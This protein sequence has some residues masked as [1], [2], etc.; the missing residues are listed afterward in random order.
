MRRTLH[1]I[2]RD[3]NIPL[4]QC[5]N[6]AKLSQAAVDE[7]Q[8]L[9]SWNS[10]F[11]EE[12]FALPYARIIHLIRDPRDVLLSGMRY[13]R[14]APLGRE[15]FLAKAAPGTGRLNYQ[16]HLN[17]LPDDHH[18][19]IFEMENKH[20][21]TIS[22]MARWTYGRTRV[23]ELKYEDLIE[24]HD[25][26]V[27]RD[28]LEKFDIAGLDINRAI[29]SYWRNSLFGGVKIGD[30]DIGAQHGK[31]LASGKKR[32]WE[33][34]MP[35]GIAEIY[36]ERYGDTLRQLGYE[37]NSDWVDSCRAETDLTS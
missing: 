13:H 36:A 35:R 4:M 1:D 33:S 16:E 17:A 14:I 32:Q 27:F 2:K 9:V 34:H 11:P 21:K 15:K 37:E 20:H 25:C 23:V 7:A 28:I 31:H 10:G 24:D 12:L 6:A 29:Q 26:A 30:K 19:L 18:R 3:Q 22:E 5:Q 8:I